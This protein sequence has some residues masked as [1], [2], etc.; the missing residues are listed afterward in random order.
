M[1]PE[2]RCP[3]CKLWTFVD[4]I[5]P[6]ASGRMREHSTND[7]GDIRRAVEKAARDDKRYVRIGQCRGVGQAPV[8]LRWPTGDPY[9]GAAAGV[10]LQWPG[11][12]VYWEGP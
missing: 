5:R 8:Q 11:G 10:R 9:L 4:G 7:A 3:V 1:T 6:G 2:G 12:A